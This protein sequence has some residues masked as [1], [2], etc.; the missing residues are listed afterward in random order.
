M[1]RFHGQDR[2][3]ES[4]ECTGVYPEGNGKPLVDCKSYKD[5]FVQNRSRTHGVLGPLAGVVEYGPGKGKCI[6]KASPNFRLG[7]VKDG[8][9]GGD[10][11]LV[12]VLLT[13]TAKVGRL[14]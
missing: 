12:C 5:S 13:T 3:W 2:P 10:H 9:Y 6:V 8:M 4:K 7:G 1:E 14:N 11:I